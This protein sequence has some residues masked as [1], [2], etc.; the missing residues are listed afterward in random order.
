MFGYIVANGKALTAEQISRYRGCYCGLC[1]SLAQQHGS[2]S[3]LTLSYDLVFIVLL[4]SSLYEPEEQQGEGRCITHPFDRHSY[5]QNRFSAYGADMNLALSY[6][7]CLDDWQDEK[8]LPELASAKLLRSSYQQIA[9]KYP[10]QCQAMEHNL[11][12]LAVL[13]KANSAAADVAAGYFGD[14]MGQLLVYRQDEW[15]EILYA[16][17]RS[18]GIFIY[19]MD[20]CLDLPR[21]QKKGLYNPLLALGGNRAPEADRDLLMMLMGDCAAQFEKLPLVQDIGILRNIVYS[22]V[23]QRYNAALLKKDKAEKNKAERE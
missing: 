18:L 7:K 20:A 6:F 19:M 2:L 13:E 3:R 15:Q 14:L 16:L 1:R 9:P 10:R 4:L 5:W 22:G 8:K 21:D 11:A 17:G 12:Q 23:W